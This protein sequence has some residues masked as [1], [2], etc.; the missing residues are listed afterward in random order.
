MDRKPWRR[1]YL[2]TAIGTW[3]ISYYPLLM[4]ARVISDV[5]R[6]GSVLKENYPKYIIPYTP[7]SIALIAGVF[8]MPVF[9]RLFKERNFHAGAISSTVVFLIF[10]LIFEKK[11]LV[12]STETVTKLEDWQMYMCYVPPEGWGQT[13]TEHK[14]Q[15]A[16]E[17]LMGEYNPAFKLH[18]Y[19][20]SILL[21]LA[22]LNCVYGFG[23][24]VK[25]GEK[26][27]GKSLVIQAACTAIFTGLCILA[28]FTAFWRDGSLE[29]SPLSAAMMAV[30]FIVMGV[31]A[32]VFAG[33]FLPGTG[34]MASVWIS[35]IAAS[36]TT[37]VMY[38]GEMILLNGHLYRLGHGYFFRSI[39]GMVFSAADLAIILLSGGITAG[40][41]TLLNRRTNS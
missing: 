10:E 15:T 4:G 26:K 28:C 40:I 11:V 20:I 19:V 9:M 2:F 31:T 39:P 7:V 27:R 33:S 30:Y 29:I 23:E 14:T 17:I 6:Y 8:L 18:F 35:A 41:F 1:Y 21:I 24:I 34:R 3:I 32:G 13:I 36:G 37:L 25:T 12:S 16:V 5:M 38:L 22:V